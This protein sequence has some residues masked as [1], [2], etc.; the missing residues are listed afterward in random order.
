MRRRSSAFM[1]LAVALFLAIA[2]VTLFG[3]LFAADATASEATRQAVAGPGLMVIAGAFGEIAVLVAF[4]VVVNAL[5][6][7]LRQQHRELALLR[8]VAATPRQVRWLVRRQVVA[9]TLLVTVPAWG[10]GVVAARR[11]L[12]ETQRLGLAAP[13][14][15]VN[16][17][18]VPMVVALAAAL[19]VGLVAAA[20][21]GR[22]ITRIA[23]A[24]ARTATSTEQGRTG[25][26]RLLAGCVAL[27]GGGLLLRLSATRPPTSR[28]R[29]GRRRC[30]VPWC[31]W[32]P[33]PWR[34]R[35][36]HR[37]GPWHPVRGGWPTP[38][39]AVTQAGCRP[40]WCPS[41]CSWACRAPR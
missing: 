39:C 33:S 22:R 20:F 21:A 37:C 25:A 23:P 34:P 4:F 5:G 11:F 6:Y 1:G 3:S 30:S 12:T 35:W 18:P 36:G 29:R 38:T 8:T 32:S 41:R 40:R 7:A 19:G 15:R 9:T 24:A 26:L 27:V 17:T 14:L 16:W 13:G 31:C 10:V 2:T 28:T